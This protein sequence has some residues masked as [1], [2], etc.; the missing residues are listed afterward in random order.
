VE[1]SLFHA[2]ASSDSPLRSAK[3]ASRLCNNQQVSAD[4]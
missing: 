3:G 4:T 1:A 2:R